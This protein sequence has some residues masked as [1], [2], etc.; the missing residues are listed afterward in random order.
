MDKIT[1]IGQSSDELAALATLLTLEGKADEVTIISPEEAKNISIPASVGD[2]TDKLIMNTIKEIAGLTPEYTPNKKH[3]DHRNSVIPNKY[4]SRPL[5]NNK[6][7]H[8]RK[9]G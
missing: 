8:N 1:L 7:R 5:N 6:F 4:K 2:M 9:R 3:S